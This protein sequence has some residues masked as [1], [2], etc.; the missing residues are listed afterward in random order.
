MARTPARF[1]CLLSLAAVL[2]GCGKPATVARTDTGAELVAR[3]FFEALARD[4]W[5][6]AYDLLDPASQAWCGMTQFINRA[7][8]AAGQIGFKP[9]QISVSVTETGEHASAV[10]VFR[11]SPGTNTKQYK[12]GAALKKLERGW[13]VV[14]RTNFGLAAPVPRP[15]PRGK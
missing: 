5:Q 6:A 1:P 2:A 3:S 10:A 11:E 4:D 14:L 13:G 8:A 15:G 12:E 9:T 7:R